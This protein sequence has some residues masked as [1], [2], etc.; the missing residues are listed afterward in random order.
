MI[1]AAVWVVV[2]LAVAVGG[3]RMGVGTLATPASGFVPTL[4]GVALAGLGSVVLG[5]A[6]RVARAANLLLPAA[7][8]VPPPSSAAGQRWRVVAAAGSIL[9]YGLLLEPLGFA[10]TTLLVLGSLFRFLGG[11]G[12]VGTVTAT[13][14]GTAFSYVL[15]ARWLNVP[16][17][18]GPWGF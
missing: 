4:A 14:A 18:P 5:R 11:L 7:P 17:P 6:W 3:V 16:F 12:W 9:A 15:F 2:G 13:V 1:S 8:A 10:V